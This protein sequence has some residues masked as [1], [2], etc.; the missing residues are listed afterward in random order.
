[1]SNVLAKGVISNVSKYKPKN[2]Q[3][4]VAG[5]FVAD[6]TVDDTISGEE[7]E[8]SRVYKGARDL[9]DGMT[10]KVTE[11]E[12]GDRMEKVVTVTSG[13]KAASQPSR[14]SAPAARSGGYKAD[15]AKDERITRM[16]CMN[17]AN[18]FLATAV[19]T[20]AL[21]KGVM[22]SEKLMFQTMGKFANLFYQAAQD[23]EFFAALPTFEGNINEVGEDDDA[24]EVQPKPKAAKK[25]VARDESEEDDD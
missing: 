17:S 21:K 15:P 4:V 7:I 20:G 5:Y 13:G 16:A 19:A 25:P 2:K 22:A 18:A 9:E 6:F 1:M 12:N 3:G 8:F 14:S 24:E 11:E 10:V 23:G